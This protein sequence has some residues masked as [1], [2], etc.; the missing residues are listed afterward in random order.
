VKKLPSTRESLDAVLGRTTTEAELD[1]CVQILTELKRACM[2]ASGARTM[3]SP[4]VSGFLSIMQ[5]SL[6]IVADRIKNRERPAKKENRDR[7]T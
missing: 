7:K 5:Q 1:E 4:E 3:P 6:G 2:V